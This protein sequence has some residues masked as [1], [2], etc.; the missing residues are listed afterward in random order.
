[1][2][3]YWRQLERSKGLASLWG[4]EQWG[5]CEKGASAFRDTSC[6]GDWN[7]CKPGDT[8][9][10]GYCWDVFETYVGC[11]G[12]VPQPCS[13]TSTSTPEERMAFALNSSQPQRWMHQGTCCWEIYEKSPVCFAR[14]GRSWPALM[15]DWY[16]QTRE[17]G[18]KLWTLKFRHS[19]EWRGE[20]GK[21]AQLEC[22]LLPSCHP[23]K[24]AFW[25][26]CSLHCCSERTCRVFTHPEHNVMSFLYF[27]LFMTFWWLFKPA[28][29]LHWHRRSTISFILYA[30]HTQ[31]VHAIVR[32]AINPSPRRSRSV[33]SG[34]PPLFNS[35]KLRS[36][37]WFHMTE[38]CRGCSYVGGHMCTVSS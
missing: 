30:I 13:S 19:A 11:G 18:L 8:M 21:S 9:N 27:A 6:W 14:Q 24:C 22:S 29:W 33:Q 5:G 26:R 36:C 38:T 32:D 31:Y 3:H 10:S 34:I 16:I 1:M 35:C 23:T 7:W 12:P 37:T 15:P 4:V 2:L 28:Q 20:R 25:A 17:Q